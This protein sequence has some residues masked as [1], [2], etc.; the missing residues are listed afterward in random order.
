MQE[1]KIRNSFSNR[2]TPHLITVDPN[3]NIWWSEGWAGKIGELQVSKAVP[4]TNKGMK[5]YAYNLPWGSCSSNHTSGIS[6]DSNGLIWFDDAE[7]E[8]FGSFPDSGTGTFQ[9]TN[10]TYWGTA[11]NQERDTN[12]ESFRQFG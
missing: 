1:Y 9:R 12:N 5:E 8:I 10:Q 11:I 6:V 3:G 2:L 4:G 7:Q